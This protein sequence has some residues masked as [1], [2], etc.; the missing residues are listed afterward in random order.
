MSGAIALLIII[1]IACYWDFTTRKREQQKKIDYYNSAYYI[2][3]NNDYK[4]VMSDKGLLGEY[5]TY[6][7][8]KWIEMYGGKF[9]YNVYLPKEN[10]TTTEMDLLLMT[11]K[12]LFV[13]ESKNYSGAIYGKEDDKYWTQ[14]LNKYTKESFYNPIKQN[15]THIEFLRKQLNKDIPIYSIIVFSQRCRLAKVPPFTKD[16]FVI[17]RENVS[18][19]IKQIIYHSNNDCLSH[20]EIDEIQ[21]HLFLFSQKTT[22]EKQEHIDNIKNNKVTNSQVVNN[23]VFNRSFTPDERI[24]SKLKEFRINRS[25]EKKIPAY[26]VFT[27]AE[28]EKLIRIK[29]TTIEELRK[30]QILQSI[31]INS[32]GR[33][34]VRIIE[35]CIK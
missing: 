22:Q 2:Y 8:L 15:K 31:K 28:M 12:G 25:K 17:K 20:K 3:T 23:Q 32:H 26:Y 11:T 6:K 33:E 19:T 10:G 24:R 35:E 7:K 34:I 29:P 18:D 14:Y 5:E 1:A 21:K 30:S 4:K 13:F 9:L 27:D 16:T